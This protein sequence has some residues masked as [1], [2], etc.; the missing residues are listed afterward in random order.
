MSDSVSLRTGSADGSGCPGSGG[1]HVGTTGGEGG[2]GD[3]E[4][5]FDGRPSGAGDCGSESVTGGTG[6][7]SC[8][9]LTSAA[10]CGSPSQNPLPA[11]DGDLQRL[12]LPWNSP[13]LFPPLPLNPLPPPLPG[14][15]LHDDG[16][17]APCVERQN[18]H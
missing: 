1:T 9:G 18:A 3:A 5:G 10:F 14:V 8:I 2:K 7:L 11:A 17:S 6:E 15:L 4:T 16:Y 12:R 13:P